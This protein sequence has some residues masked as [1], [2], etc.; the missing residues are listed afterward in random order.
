MKIAKKTFKRKEYPEVYQAGILAYLFGA[1]SA[2]EQLNAARKFEDDTI[3]DAY[4]EAVA[5]FLAK[6]VIS[7]EDFIDLQAEFKKKAFTIAKLEDEFIISKIKDSLD[8]S[9]AND[10]NLADWVDEINVMFDRIGITRLQPHYLELVFKNATGEAITEG[11]WKL[12]GELD[13]EEFP[14][15]E[16]IEIIDG[17]TRPEHIPLNGFRAPVSDPIWNKMRGPLDH[18][19][20]GT[21]RPVHKDEGLKASNWT[22]TLSGRG[23]AFVN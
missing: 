23:F 13:E 11:K 3:P 7:A 4:D 17:R 14:L 8:K 21:E 22:P 15:M 18:G 5:F 12:Y 1:Y 20:R 6:E 16:R 9:I 10:V 19:C 2:K